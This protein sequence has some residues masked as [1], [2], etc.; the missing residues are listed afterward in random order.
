[1][2]CYCFQSEVSIHMP[3]LLRLLSVQLKILLNPVTH[4]EALV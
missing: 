4:L 3:D 2:S 1:M